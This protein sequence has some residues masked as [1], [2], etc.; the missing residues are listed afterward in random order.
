M[1]FLLCRRQGSQLKRGFTTGTKGR[2]RCVNRAGD[3][4]PKGEK[5]FQVFKKARKT[6]STPGLYFSS[7]IGP[8]YGASRESRVGI[9]TLNEPV[10]K[11]YF[12]VRMS[13]CLHAQSGGV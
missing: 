12:T 6:P 1:L 9:G 13:K 8:L 10:K 5:D 3:P 7:Q 11:Y 2:K 4:K